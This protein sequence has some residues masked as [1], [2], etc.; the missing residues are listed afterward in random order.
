MSSESRKGKD[1]V[2]IANCSGFFGDRLAAASEMVQGRS[3]RCSYRR[4]P[5]RAY[6]GASL[7]LEIEKP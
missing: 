4:L 1:R 7:P 3:N 6:Y 5:C 2:I